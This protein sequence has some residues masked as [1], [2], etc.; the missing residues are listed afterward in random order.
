M[1][2]IKN[3]TTRAISGT[4]L[5]AVVVAATLW[6]ACSRDILLVAIGIGC[7][8]ELLNLIR[9]EGMRTMRY[10]ICACSA[11]LLLFFALYG[12]SYIVAFVAVAM[13]LARFVS[14]LYTRHETPF[15]NIALDLFATLYTVVPVA[16]AMTLGPREL[17]TLFVMVWV[18]DVG[19]FMV[20]I[21]A[22]RHK[23]FERLSP[24]KTWEGCI[25]GVVLTAAVGALMGHLLFDG[26]IWQWAVIGLL[27]SVSAVLGDL[28]ESMIKRSIGI[29]DSGNVIP[30]HGG[31][32]DRFDAFLFAAPVFW[33]SYNL[34]F[35]LITIRI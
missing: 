24:K 18:S 1:A 13:I 34:I 35:N 31:M 25:G 26:H 14:E 28:F 9:K 7:Q 16:V 30:G 20:G 17:L 32:L 12:L 6:N 27:T 15:Q 19:A 23:L 22:G 3:I 10:L 2:D 11:L 21:T 33:V 8:I 4:V 5:V 29:K